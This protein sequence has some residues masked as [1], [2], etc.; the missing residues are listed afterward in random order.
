MSGRGVAGMRIFGTVLV[1]L[2]TMATGARP[3][4]AD[5]PP[6]RF[7][8]SADA[9]TVL[10]VVTGLI[11]QRQVSPDTRNWADSG[12]YCVSL[13]V[14]P[15]VGGYTTAWR[16]PGIK[17]LSSI[18]DFRRMD[19]AID[20]TAFPGTVSSHFFSV[21]ID[22][23]AAGA[24]HTI[25]FGDGNLTTQG[26]ANT[27]LARCVRSVYALSYDGVDDCTTV[28]ELFSGGSTTTVTVEAWLRHTGAANA[29]AVEQ[30]LFAHRATDHDIYLSYVPNASPAR[31]DW[32]F[33]DGACPETNVVRYEVDLG[34]DRWHHI[35]G[36]FTS[37]TLS[38]FIDGV[39][40]A[41]QTQASS[42]MDWGSSLSNSLGCNGTENQRL[43]GLLGGVRVSSTARYTTDFTPA[44]LLAV[45][46]DT[47]A[48]WKMDEG[49]GTTASDADGTN[50]G[51]I[52]DAAW[53]TTAMVQAP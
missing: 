1:A 11:W 3:S 7:V 34:D 46:A 38:L 26:I 44:W 30:H 14:A 8:V 43:N 6:G 13:N 36:A 33:C 16:L 49:T 40:V 25:N 37:G 42:Q 50:D 45:D 9:E 20:P 28:G 18:I 23:D 52:S 10:D 29:G 51:T 17:E 4:L 35:A 5:A 32:G 27:R 47:H 2:V 15:G 24:A 22:A 12:A 41:T 48:L 19:P 21:R 39:L 53:V 31:I